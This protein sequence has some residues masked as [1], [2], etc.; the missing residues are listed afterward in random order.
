MK[1]FLMNLI[2][3]IIS[4]WNIRS[5]A[6]RGYG[7]GSEKIG[8]GFYT[9]VPYPDWASAVAASEYD[10]ET[11]L[12]R[13]RDATRMVC[14]GKAVYERDSVLFERIEY[15]WPLTAGLMWAA[16]RHGGELR[17]LDFGGSLG[18]TW[19]QNRRFLDGL[20]TVRWHIVE[21]K[22][23][24]ACG[25]KEFQTEELRFY[26]SI[27]ECL[28]EAKV[29]GIVLSGVLQYMED[30]YALADDICAIGLDFLLF[31]RLTLTEGADEFVLHCVPTYKSKIAY[32]ILNKS[33]LERI[34]DKDYEIV[35]RFAA[36]T[37]GPGYYG[38]MARKKEKRFED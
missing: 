21:L 20:K 27:E 16:A 5:R 7:G 19:R 35:E 15:S 14:D 18:T 24:V 8:G 11:H 4:I 9:N 32:H 1:A 3:N 36:Q 28:K 31:D 34:V 38:F 17:V 6:R 12:T 2:S 25:R 30:P 10:A 33:E 23:F 26:D 13:V 22:H 37:D 29:D